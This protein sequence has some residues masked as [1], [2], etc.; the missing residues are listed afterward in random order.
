[1]TA[2]FGIVIRTSALLVCVRLLSLVL[3][4]AS[5]SVRHALWAIGLLAVLVFPVVSRWIPEWDIAI[6]PEKSIKTSSIDTTPAPVPLPDAVSVIARSE[7]RQPSEN[8]APVVAS[9]HL[10][11]AGNWIPRW[12]TGQWLA[13]LYLLGSGVFL[14]GWLKSVWDLHRLTQ[15][16]RPL[17]GDGWDE[18]LLET[19][20]EIG[21]PGTIQLRTSTD[22]I[23]PM[24]WGIFRPVILLPIAALDWAPIRQRLVL[25][26]E[27][28]HVKRYDSVGQLLAQAVST[29]Y[30]F[31]PVVWYAVHRLHAER[32]RACDDSVLRLGADGADY[33][34]H[35]LQITRGLNTGFSQSAVS[36]AHAS[37]LK[38]RLIA[39]LDSGMA[40]SRASRIAATTL[41]TTIGVLTLSI[42][43]IQVT[44]L[45]TL[46]LPAFA[47]PYGAPFGALMSRPK[48][49]EVTPPLPAAQQPVAAVVDPQHT[50]INQY[51]LSCHN[52]DDRVANVMFDAPV[53][54]VGHVEE[55]RP[56][57]E[58]VVR[59]LRAGR[60]SFDIAGI[61]RPSAA[62]IKSM[63]QYLE[64]ELD[65][66][67]KTYIPPIAPHRLNRTEYQNAIRDLLDLEIDST[68]LLPPD[69]YTSGFDNIL[70]APDSP[71]TRDAY[72][73]VAPIISRLAV[74]TA[75]SSSSYQRVFVCTPPS[76]RREDGEACAK[77]IITVLTENA[78]R[79]DATAAD[80]DS[81][82]AAYAAGRNGGNFEQGIGAALSQILASSK[83]IYRT[84]AAPPDVKPGD[85]YRISDLALASRL[86]FFLWS[87]SPDQDLIDLA[88]QGKLHEPAVLEQQTI[89]MLKDYRADALS[90]NFAGQWLN[91]R[92]LQSVAP[93]PALFPAFDEGL[94]QAMRREDELFFDSIVREDRNVVDL[95]TADYTFVNN[96]LARHYGIPNISGNQ[97]RRIPLTDTFDARRGI[98]GKAAF[99]TMTSLDNRTRPM[100]R[101]KWIM[102]NLLGVGPPDPPPNV[103]PMK[104]RSNDPG[105][106]NPSMRKAMEDEYARY[107]SRE[108]AGCIS[109]HRLADP[110][111]FSLENFNA[112]GVWRTEDG[113]APVNAADTL[114]DGTSIN[115]PA[116][117]RRW[118]VGYSDQFV[119]V[120]TQKLMTYAL[121]RRIEPQDMPLIRAIDREVA[122]NN[123]RFS[124]IVLGIVKS[125]T[126][127]MNSK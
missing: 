17:T 73:G 30:W 33:A 69:D 101:A 46:V 119:Q 94:R 80:V 121:G 65:R 29:I 52:Y 85:A 19:Q 125:D 77:T 89:R 16:S 43:A 109:C 78:F 66:N 112:I 104:P 106:L 118:L 32:E 48:L 108:R 87:T 113:G 35:L 14:F 13:L 84:E 110:I 6:L 11:A 122:R 9:G 8:P 4:R 74:Q 31:N 64:T 60:D 36:M 67:A 7:I 57:W 70:T 98:L 82:M 126:F 12:G 10:Q 102:S 86:S 25:A 28:A 39:I 15:R 20:R 79:G 88:K 68:Q 92:S 27:M 21:V 103:L 54:D 59:R 38:V 117:L 127:Q 105:V 1:M 120:M 95:L 93:I 90:I 26:H 107:D 83:F 96:R 53:S 97:F 55:N 62:S 100:T 42:A 41:L 124:A 123:N 76:Y 44:A 56:L 49:V 34:D 58:K 99:L 23:S 91:L 37:Q 47:A 50:F 3:R 71:R 116:D 114:Y 72:T 81:S 5:A 75:P 61:G 111:G 2:A 40:R 24:M 51:C 115:G 18:R 22:A 63:I 45:S